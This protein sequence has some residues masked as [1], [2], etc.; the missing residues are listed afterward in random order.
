MLKRS[1]TTVAILAPFMPRLQD[2]CCRIKL[3]QLVS[4]CRRQHVSC[5]GD[6]TVVGLSSVCCW[7]Q[8]DTIR[9]WHKW[10]VIMSPR[11]SQHVSRTSNLYPAT[12]VRRHNICI[13]IPDTSCSSG[14][15]VS[16]RHVFRCKRGIIWP[17][18][19]HSGIRKCRGTTLQA[20]HVFSTLCLR[21]KEHFCLK[22]EHF[23]FC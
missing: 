1:T 16:G 19:Q 20:I 22:K 15:H 7:I 12:Y 13:R 5:I 23:C 11:Y 4:S 2:T 6:K 17:L 3:Y 8:R 9:P 21:K 18:G 14:I 10:I